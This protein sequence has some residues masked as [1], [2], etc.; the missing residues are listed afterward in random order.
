M[1]LIVLAAV[2]GTFMALAPSA[3]A[4]WTH[5]GG[6]PLFPGGI[7]GSGQTA[8]NDFVRKMNTNRAAKAMKRAGLS[9]AERKAVRNAVNKGRFK[10]CTLN[11]G[12]TFQKMSFGAGTIFVDRNVTFA[13]PNY[14]D[15][16]SPAFCLTVKVKK[17]GGKVTTIKIKV[18]FVCVNFAVI[19]KK[20]TKS[21]SKN[22]GCNCTLPP[23]PPPGGCTVVVNGD[24]SGNAGCGNVQICTANGNI[25]GNQTV[26][27]TPPPPPPPTCEETGTCNL[28]PVGE[29]DASA[30][31]V[32][33]GNRRVQLYFIG[34]DP[35][36]D[37]IVLDILLDAPAGTYISGKTKVTQ[38][39]DPDRTCPSDQTCWEATLW[40]GNTPGDAWVSGKFTAGGESFTTEPV[41]IVVALD[42]FPN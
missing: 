41:K 21:P 40:S 19:S 16:G 2:V 34:D 8:R 14:K 38:F 15:S 39:S 25:G 32:Q 35:N 23:P 36:G 24:N 3:N 37:N 4:S 42:Q 29:I 10:Q 30:A 9:A 20:T 22:K 1:R 28:P 7:K 26:C 33:T 18:P 6:D 5:L 13:D 11:Y 31:H 17:K 12:D 27:V